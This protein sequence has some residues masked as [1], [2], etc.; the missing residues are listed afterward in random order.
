M[1]KEAI[2]ACAT[3]LHH[4]GI[5]MDADQAIVCRDSAEGQQARERFLT[6]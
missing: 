6:R 1:S 5:Y 4:M 3:P 2:N